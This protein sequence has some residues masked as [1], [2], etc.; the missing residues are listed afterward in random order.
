MDLNDVYVPSVGFTESS[1]VNSVGFLKNDE[2]FTPVPKDGVAKPA[3]GMKFDSMDEARD[4]Y[5]HY[6]TSSGF[7]IKIASSTS[8]KNKIKNHQD[9]VLE[10]TT[11]LQMHV[12][13]SNTPPNKLGDKLRVTLAC[14]R[15]VQ[16]PKET[17]DPLDREKLSYRTNC[18]ARI[19][20]KM[21]DNGKVGISG[22]VEKHNHKFLEDD[23]IHLLPSKRNVPDSL[24]RRI[25]IN[26]K[27]GIGASKT[28]ANIVAEAGGHRNVPFT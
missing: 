5:N 21:I 2:F 14:S 3:I 10:S 27:A 24:K 13:D 19:N 28:M 9:V 11:T 26:D 25:E 17:K 12:Y 1:F 6:A 18:P 16:P 23:M 22:L 8:Y 4:F 7:G 15:S 20:L